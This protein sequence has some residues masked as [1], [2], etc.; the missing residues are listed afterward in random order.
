M[1]LVLKVPKLQIRTTFLEQLE[2]A[3]NNKKFHLVFL[4]KSLLSSVSL[5]KAQ[6]LGGERATTTTQ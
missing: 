3:Y 6:R 5:S 2:T 4:T 1:K